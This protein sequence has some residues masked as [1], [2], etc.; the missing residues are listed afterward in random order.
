MPFEETQLGRYRLQQQ[1]GSGGMGEV[2]LAVDTHINRQV[3]VKIIRSGATAYPNEE[4]TREAARLFQR[5]MRA[6]AVLD[7][8]NI[9]PL[10]DYGEEIMGRT[11]LTYMVMPYRKEGSLADWLQQRSKKGLLSLPEITRLIQQA[12]SALQHAH[13]HKILHQDVKPSNFLIH[14][15]DDEPDRP[16]L[17]LADFGVAKFT[18][19]TASM[20]Q[21]I[22]GTPAYM[23][24]EQW[25]GT[26][27]PASD[28]YALAIM[29]YEL[30]T[31]RPPFQGG[32]GQ[33]M[34]Q[35]FNTPPQPPSTL[36]PAIPA[37]LDTVLLHALAKKPEERFASIS[38]FARAFQEAAKSMPTTTIPKPPIAQPKLQQQTPVLPPSPTPPPASVPSRGKDLRA[39]LAITYEE[40][41]RGT[42]RTLTLPGGRRT[43]VSIPSGAQNGQTLYLPGQGEPPS[44]GSGETGALIITIAVAPREESKPIVNQPSHEDHTFLSVPPKAETRPPV[45]NMAATRPASQT[46]S[47]G[48]SRKRGAVLIVLAAMVI[49]AGFITFHSFPSDLFT[50]TT[51]SS[52]TLPPASSFQRLAVNDSLNNVTNGWDQ[53]S[54]S[55]STCTFSKGGY[56]VVLSYLR[57][58]YCLDRSIHFSK[59]AYQIQL[60]LL[61]GDS[62]GMA[63]L[64]NGTNS[65]AGSGYYFI[66]GSDSSYEFGIIESGTLQLLT[67]GT[68]SA[69]QT[70]SNQTNLLEVTANDGNIYLYINSQLISHVSDSTYTSG[71]IGVVAYNTTSGDTTEAV[72]NNA[73]VWTM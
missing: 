33:M 64:A 18:S 45:S 27:V 43:T 25:E 3:A 29:A 38:A 13:N 8:P 35:H 4:S 16:N 23:S 73:K 66:I 68:S 19:A 22:R 1:L 12:A 70:G 54:N 61:N 37:D 46:Q 49:I 40:A 14:I 51:T 44:T 50:S 67:N 2:Y 6:I 31:G 48:F 32:M 56:R 72:F 71:Q 52:S 30:L 17:Q 41:Q 20:S 9:L 57:F 36:N 60:T 65:E 26:P 10:Y 34:Y 42:T 28:Q 39:T 69:I 47:R 59:F 24:P 55:T 11:T 5:E 63:F 7:H 15:S 21:A 62:A 58:T 53:G